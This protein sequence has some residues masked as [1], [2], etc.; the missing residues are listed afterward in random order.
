MMREAAQLTI[1]LIRKPWFR[2]RVAPA[3]PFTHVTLSHRPWPHLAG[4]P[5][6]L[7][8]TSS[9]VENQIICSKTHLVSGYLTQIETWDDKLCLLSFI[10]SHTQKM[11]EQREGER[12]II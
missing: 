8:P 1:L 11:V 5:S 4:G 12:E 10:L 9:T 7:L 6:A 3:A 2:G